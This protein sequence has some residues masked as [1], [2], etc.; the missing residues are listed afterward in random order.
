MVGR[1]RVI[2]GDTNQTHGQRIRL[3]GIDPPESDQN[4]EDGLGRR[5]PCGDESARQRSSILSGSNTTTCLDLD[6]D[7]YGR[8]V[9]DYHRANGANVASELVGSGYALDWPRHSGGRYDHEQRAAMA[10]AAGIW[11]GSFNEP[12][13]WR[14]SQRSSSG[15][16]AARS[17]RQPDQSGSSCRIKGNINDRGERIYHVPG[18][19]HYRET[20]I[21]VTRGERMFCLEGEAQAAGWRRSRV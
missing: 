8:I 6:R 14:Q 16:G 13:T 2:D 4:C 12:W 15:D 18:Q 10:A 7:A 1:A 21:S 19:R 9:A 17:F 5:Y 20:S 3:N 11:R